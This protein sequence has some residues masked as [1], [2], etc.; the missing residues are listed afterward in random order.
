MDRAINDL[1][2]KAHQTVQKRSATTDD[3]SFNLG[4]NISQISVSAILLL[5][6]IT[7]WFLLQ[8]ALVVAFW[9]LAVWFLESRKIHPAT[10]EIVSRIED[11][12]GSDPKL[13]D[14]LSN[15]KDDE[16]LAEFTVD[17]VSAMVESLSQVKKNESAIVV[18]VMQNL[19][20]H[21]RSSELID[22]GFN[23]DDQGDSVVRLVSSSV[24]QKRIFDLANAIY[25]EQEIGSV[26]DADE[27]KKLTNLVTNNF[28]AGEQQNNKASVV[29]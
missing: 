7:Q 6:I 5:A 10:R 21:K 11:N 14:L 19:K 16:D 24:C 8:I 1:F 22:M 17:G 25:T 29:H 9:F 12:I 13:S 15:E 26:V 27:I 20:T 23:L 4:D 18:M 28:L 3:E 2:Y